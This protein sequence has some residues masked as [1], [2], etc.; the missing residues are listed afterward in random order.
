MQRYD[1]GRDPSCGLIL[2]EMTE[3]PNGEYVKY[4]DVEALI[5]KLTAVYKRLYGTSLTFDLDQ[6]KFLME[7]RLTEGYDCLAPNDI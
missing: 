2:G 7:Y 1:L 6:S 3:D 4:A 5:E